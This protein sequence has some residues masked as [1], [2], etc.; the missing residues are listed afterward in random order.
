MTSV[1]APGAKIHPWSRCM[2]A[3]ISQARAAGLK[4]REGSVFDHR[5]VHAASAAGGGDLE[6]VNPAP[7][8]RCG[9]RSSIPR[10]KRAASVQPRTQQAGAW[11]NCR[12]ASGGARSGIISRSNRR[13]CHRQDDAPRTMVD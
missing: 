5:D 3:T 13:T 7:R 2:A 10:R 11:R 1:T 6:A 9:I 4:Q 12:E 8:W